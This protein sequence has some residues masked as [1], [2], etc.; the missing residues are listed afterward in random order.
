LPLLHLP[1]LQSE[2]ELHEPH[3]LLEHLPTLQSEFELHEP[4]EPLEQLQCPLQSEFELHE[5]HLPLE[6]LPKPA[7]SEF[8][9]HARSSCDD[10][11]SSSVNCGSSCIPLFSY[12]G[13][14]ATLLVV[15]GSLPHATRKAIR[16]TSFMGAVISPGRCRHGIQTAKL[17]QIAKDRNPGPES[18][19]S[20]E[21]LS[22]TP[23]WHADVHG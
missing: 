19:S 7:Q 8:E 2:L 11:R 14:T 21:W 4:H 23:T 16:M 12:C 3:L 18:G 9:L 1:P 17:P 20:A 5:P 13:T 10:S 22:R 15:L 6:H